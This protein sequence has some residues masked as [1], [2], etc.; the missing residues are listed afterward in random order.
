LAQMY[1]KGQ[2]VEVDMQQAAFW[3]KK[4]ASRYAYVVEEEQEVLNEDECFID[5]VKKQMVPTAEKKGRQYAFRKVDTS[6]PEV[7][8]ILLKYFEN[9]FGL[10]HYRT[11]Y[12]APFALA[13]KKY[14]RHIAAYTDVTVPDEFR[15]YEYYDDDVEVELQLSFRKPLTFDLFGWNEY[16]DFTYTQQVWW[17]LY[18]SSAP[19]RETNYIPELFMTIPTS[20][21]IENKYH[22]KAVSLGYRHQSNGQEGYHSRSWDRL[23]VL[24]RWQFA[25][26]F[27][28][29]QAWYRIPEERKSD[30]YYAGY[31]QS[32]IEEGDDN[33]DIDKYM[34]YGDVEMTYLYKE[35]QFGLLVRNN[36]R[37]D[38]KGA[39]QLDWSMPF[40]NSS[41]TYWYA[42][43]FSGYGESMI[44]YDES[45]TKLSLGFAYSRGLF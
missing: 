17:K 9:S 29:A 1:E 39:I 24:G 13:N 23:F 40:I 18:D 11:N 44:S 2:G 30:A 45:V 16:I 7:K 34:G 6:T 31:G 32:P 21:Y 12:V 27:L 26:L 20:D 4:V 8:S 28:K 41:N 25:N 36:L 15:D 5:R 19:F 10:I 38:N 43:L 42:K 37:S 14:K 22:L 33:P 35:H 3:Y